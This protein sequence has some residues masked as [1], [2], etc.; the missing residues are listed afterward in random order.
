MQSA[1]QL[2]RQARSEHLSGNPAFI[3]TIIGIRKALDEG[4]GAINVAIRNVE[5]DAARKQT[6]RRTILTML[7]I[8][9][10]LSASLLLFLHRRR[11]PALAAA[12]QLLSVSQQQFQTLQTSIDAV[13]VR[14]NAILGTLEQFVKR[15]KT[16][17]TLQV[18]QRIATDFEVIQAMTNAAKQVFSNVEGLIYPSSLGAQVINLFSPARYLEGRNLL[19]SKVFDVGHKDSITTVTGTPETVASAT[20]NSDTGSEPASQYATFDDFVSDIG[21]RR[22]STEQKLDQL[23]LCSRM[24]VP[25]LDDFEKRYVSL[26]ELAHTL[27]AEASKDGFFTVPNLVAELLPSVR[28]LIDR[29]RKMSEIDP[30]HVINTLCPGASRQIVDAN[31][32]ISFVDEIRTQQFP[33]F[34]DVGD[35]LKALNHRAKW[36]EEHVTSMGNR[37]SQLMHDACDHQMQDVLKQIKADANVFLTKL[38]GIMQVAEVTINER[39]A[40]VTVT[41]HSLSDARANVAKVLSIQTSEAIAEESLNP[42]EHLTSAE[43]AIKATVVAI[44]MGNLDGAVQAAIAA[45]EETRYAQSLVDDSLQSLNDF[46]IRYPKSCEELKDAMKTLADVSQI[47]SAAEQAYA[48]TAMIWHD[49]PDKEDDSTQTQD[50]EEAWETAPYASG[51][52]I[53]MQVESAGRI[54]ETIRSGLESARAKHASGKLREAANILRFAAEGT[55][56]SIKRLVLAKNHCKRLDALVPTNIRRAAALTT[57][58]EKLTAYV[59]D[60]R[61][62]TSTQQTHKQLQSQHQQLANDLRTLRVARDPFHDSDQLIK[63]RIALIE[64]RSL[65][66]ADFT[67]FKKAKLAVEGAR[68][69]IKA[70]ARLAMQSIEDQVP[71][72]AEIARCQN[73]TRRLDPIVT[74]AEVALLVA[75]NDWQAIQKTASDATAELGVVSG[76]L[77]Q[78]LRAAHEAAVFIATASSEVLRASRWTGAYGIAVSGQPGSQEL[79]GARNALANGDYA[80]TMSLCGNAVSAVAAANSI[81]EDEVASRRRQKEVAAAR[82]RSLQQSLFSASSGSSF[83]SSSSSWPSSSSGGSS[84]FSRSGW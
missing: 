82:R 18:A 34:D 81:A 10:V 13:H 63:H 46:S 38:H 67:A 20:G 30:V 25:T 53:S 79:E 44:D 2:L 47:I 19:G 76:S 37:L 28:R 3:Q 24:A 12:N 48:P 31:A 83:G 56:E 7:S 75:H 22:E 16:G 39:R 32:A 60:P 15:G 6:I 42:D 52:P 68:R 49:E 43:S 65:I 58:L 41:R 8:V 35:K 4:D 50:D 5:Q 71:D 64:L 72:S 78:E 57:E 55:A 70:V 59:E 27:K 14:K 51:E 40:E 33:I 36:I 29:G 26:G 9:F 66:N 45:Q 21:K 74:A 69:E 61:A 17:E 77:S 62:E 54:L 11:R 80:A 84:G 73:E 23:E 1:Q